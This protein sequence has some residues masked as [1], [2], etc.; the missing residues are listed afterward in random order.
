MKKFQE[1]YDALDFLQSLG[2]LDSP[3]EYM[4][5][6]KAEDLEKYLLRMQDLLDRVGNPERDM[7]FVHVTGTAGKGTTTA[8]IHNMLHNAGY[9]VGST[10]SPATTTTLERIKVGELFIDPKDFVILVN[11]LK[12]IITDMY[13]T[14]IYGK[15][16]YFD[17]ILAIAL[18][19]FKEQKC[20]LVVLEVGMGGRY[21]STNVIPA[22]VVSA[23]TNISLDH[24]HLLGNS[25]EAI[26]IEKAGIIKKG[27]EVFTTEQD[28]AITDIFENICNEKEAVYHQIKV[29]GN[30]N[31][32]LARSI[33]NYLDLD[34]EVIEQTIT[35]MKL[36]CRF[37]IMQNDP[38]VILDGAHNVSKVAFSLGK[39]KN[40]EYKNLSVIFGAGETKDAL[41]MLDEISLHTS[42]IALCAVLSSLGRSFSLKKMQEYIQEKYPDISTSVYTE[43]QNAF[44]DTYSN[45]EEKDALLVIGSLYLA[46]GLRKRWYSEEF[47]LQNRKSF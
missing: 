1:Y 8:L 14:S 44:E 32:S 16:S 23:I 13:M 2:K 33:G 22:P 24:T 47:I 42:N 12:P 21:D 35:Q 18:M 4:K 30:P 19:Y 40:L 27:S 10:S 36:P 43:A 7:K 17:I 25:R 5:E 11:R 29:D 15:P 46:G 37:E 41:G 9:N 34:G 39:L 6:R 3:L 20:D 38:L 28:P 45:L 31:H 26:A